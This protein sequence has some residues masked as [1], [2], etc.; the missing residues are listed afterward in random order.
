MCSFKLQAH[1]HVCT[2]CIIIAQVHTILM[3]NTGLTANRVSTIIVFG[4][5]NIETSKKDFWLESVYSHHADEI[6]AAFQHKAFSLLL[7]QIM[8]CDVVAPSL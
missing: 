3:S 5:L 8:L 7:L 2:V 4:T 1:M 6:T